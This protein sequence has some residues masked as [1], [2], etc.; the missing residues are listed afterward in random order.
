[1]ACYHPV[2]ARQDVPGGAVRLRPPLGTAT[3]LIPC[4][5][6]IGCRQA[7]AVEWSRR[8][9]HEASLYERN[10]FVTLTY[11]DV[12]LPADGSLV[13]RHL[14]LFIKRLRKAATYDE[15]VVSSGTGVRFFACGEYGESTG[16]PHYHALL[17]NCGLN[18]LYQVGK[19]LYSSDTLARLWP[20]GAHKIGTVTGASA[21]YVAKYQLKSGP[22]EYC[23]D[24]GVVLRKPFL[25]MSR[26]PG[27]GSRWLA[28]YRE[29]LRSGFL[30]A[31][32]S[33][34]RIPRA[35][36]KRLEKDDPSLFEAI[37]VE[38]AKVRRPL[39]PERLV[40]AEVIAKSR[41]SNRQ[42]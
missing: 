31:D 22:Q 15:T 5:Q 29:D 42:F 13:P 16:R 18:N 41:L 10:I 24:D 37:A 26:R 23:D 11:D 32:G 40:A 20:F 7:R 2:P 3:M 1:M 38:R 33:R 27:I 35:Y 39:E 21:G 28:R 36:L 6:C 17:F 14:Q 9:C 30:V 4:G 19:D 8:C 25:R 12:W 34:T